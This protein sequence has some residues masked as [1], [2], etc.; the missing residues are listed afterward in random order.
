MQPLKIEKPLQ[1]LLTFSY[2]KLVKEIFFRL[3]YCDFFSVFIFSVP[4]IVIT[5]VTQF[6]FLSTDIFWA[7]LRDNFKTA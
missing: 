5:I 6:I 4:S 3:F 7:L 2:T 1:C